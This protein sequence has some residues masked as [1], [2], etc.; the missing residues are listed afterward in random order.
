MRLP[1]SKRKDTVATA[2]VAQGWSSRARSIRVNDMRDHIA[3]RRPSSNWR[4]SEH[5]Q[6]FAVALSSGSNALVALA[7]ARAHGPSLVG[8]QSARGVRRDGLP[9]EGDG[10]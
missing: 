2:R 9:R 3:R 6:D 7:T 1:V 10:A 5:R 4:A 8:E